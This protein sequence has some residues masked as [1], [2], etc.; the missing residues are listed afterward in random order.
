MRG[1]VEIFRGGKGVST[2]KRRCAPMSVIFEGRFCLLPDVRSEI[3]TANAPRTASS[4][5][6]LVETVKGGGGK[7]CREEFMFK[8]GISMARIE[9]GQVVIAF[10]EKQRR[11]GSGG[12]ILGKGIC[13][14]I[15]LMG[16]GGGRSVCFNP[17]KR[18]GSTRSVTDIQPIK[19]R[20]HDRIVGEAFVLT[21][22]WLVTDSSNAIQE[23]LAVSVEGEWLCDGRGG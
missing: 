6:I 13:K 14:G 12:G 23:G 3:A 2:Q 11:R 22:A 9:G 16:E 1:A 4:P 20:A 19:D 10:N 18:G 5:N 17:L 8:D 21:R 15:E 7:S